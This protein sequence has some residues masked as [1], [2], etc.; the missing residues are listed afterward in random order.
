[1]GSEVIFCEQPSVF[2]FL[3]LFLP[4]MKTEGFRGSK[5]MWLIWST[6]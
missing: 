1:M 6:Q 3:F 4:D 5:R 2:V